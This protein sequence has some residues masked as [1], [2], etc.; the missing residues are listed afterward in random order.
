MKRATPA[1]RRPCKGLLSMGFPY[2]LEVRPEDLQ[3]LRPPEQKAQPGSG[4]SP[5][6]PRRWRQ[7]GPCSQLVLST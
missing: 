3:R 6:L 7:E 2:A 5:R 4:S 1:T